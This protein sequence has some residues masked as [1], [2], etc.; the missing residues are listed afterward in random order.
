MYQTM[1]EIKEQYDGKWVFMTNCKK[2]KLNEI[3]GGVVI[4]ANK[5]KKTV[6]EFWS[7]EYDGETYFRY[8]G[9]IPDGM[10][11]LL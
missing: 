5:N 7:K 11:V 2:G 10:G 9:D 1:N 6:A 3:V 4:V 8:I